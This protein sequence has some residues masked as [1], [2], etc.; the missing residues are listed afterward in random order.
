MVGVVAITDDAGRSWRSAKVLRGAPTAISCATATAC[1]VDT[2]RGYVSFTS[3]GGRSWRS[4]SIPGW[5]EPGCATC[6]NPEPVSGIS[7][8]NADSCVASTG[9]LGYSQNGAPLPSGGVMVTLNDGRSWTPVSVP[10]VLIDGISCA[11]PHDC[12]A[13]GQ[14]NV[15]QS[16]E[17]EM[18]HWG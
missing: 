7:C 9:G 8:W 3:D 15:V 14:S 10:A 4:S 6:S 12:W 2:D 18:I 11:G 5:S 16:T 1:A 13:F 17:P